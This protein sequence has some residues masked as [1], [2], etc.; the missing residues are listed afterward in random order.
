MKKITYML[1][2]LALLT[3]SACEDTVGVEGS[4]HIS[5]ISVALTDTVSNEVLDS[6]YT[7][8]CDTTGVVTYEDAMEVN[9]TV[10]DTIDTDSIHWDLTLC[11]ENV[12][13]SDDMS[14]SSVI[15]NSDRVQIEVT[16]VIDEAAFFVKYNSNFSS[17]TGVVALHSNLPSAGNERASINITGNSTSIDNVET[18]TF[19]SES[20]GAVFSIDRTMLINNVDDYMN[21]VELSVVNKSLITSQSL[22]DSS[23]ITFYIVLDR[24]VHFTSDATIFIGDYTSKM[25]AY[26]SHN[27]GVPTTETGLYEFTIPVSELYRDGTSDTGA[28][29]LTGTALQEVRIQ[30]NDQLLENARLDFTLTAVLCH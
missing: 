18:S 12:S 3:F 16:K 22:T 2:A 5:D 26:I 21:Y 7:Y 27:D 29:L 15:A 1:I 24:N 4:G 9:P 25:D 28:A 8:G 17:D 13:S 19:M 23:T 10:V 30:F 6:M 20:A 14:S 11:Q